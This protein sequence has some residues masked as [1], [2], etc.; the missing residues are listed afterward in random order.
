MAAVTSRA[1]QKF[2]IL[3]V[4]EPKSSKQLASAS[5]P[6]IHA[7]AVQ[8]LESC[9]SFEHCSLY[10]ENVFLVGLCNAQVSNFIIFSPEKHANRKLQGTTQEIECKTYTVENVLILVKMEVQRRNVILYNLMISL[11]PTAEDNSGNHSCHVFFYHCF[12]KSR[13]VFGTESMRLNGNGFSRTKR[14]G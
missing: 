12:S 4:G 8:A 6:F 1:T 9:S 3:L 14:V 5:V 13:V 7:S 2:L 11:F 10:C